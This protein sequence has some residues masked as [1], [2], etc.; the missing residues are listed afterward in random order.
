MEITSEES[1]AVVAFKATSLSDSEGIT[2]AASR[3]QE[4]IEENRPHKIIFDFEQVKFFSSR[5][6]GVLLAIRSK[7][8]AYNGEAVISAINPE[9]HRVIRISNLDKLFRFYPDKESAIRAVGKN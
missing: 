7:M 1:V 9:L 4:F 8:Q 3:I 5:L 6:L 2:A